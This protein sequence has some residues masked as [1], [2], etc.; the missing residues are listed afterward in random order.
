MIGRIVEGEVGASDER[1]G[2]V[3]GFLVV[4]GARDAGDEELVDGGLGVGAGAGA[5][6]V[7][8][9]GAVL[10]DGGYVGVVVVEQVWEAGAYGFAILSGYGL[11]G[12]IVHGYL[13]FLYVPVG[14]ERDIQASC[15]VLLPEEKKSRNIWVLSSMVAAR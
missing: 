6:V 7:E 13:P 14:S 1:G 11:E 8:V 2:E 9:R 4:D 3:V 10:G 5:V 15:R 12:I